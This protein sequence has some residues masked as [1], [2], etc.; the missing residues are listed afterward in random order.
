VR[1]SGLERHASFGASTHD[2]SVLYWA[3]QV[4]KGNTVVAEQL[5]VAVRER[6]REHQQAA[7]GVRTKPGEVGLHRAVLRGDAGG[8]TRVAAVSQGHRTHAVR[9]CVDFPA[10]VGEHRG[11]VGRSDARG[12]PVNGSPVTAPEMMR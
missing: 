8:V 6:S 5:G 3:M 4:G 7:V 11:L 9:G 12:L 1:K 2:A 10:H